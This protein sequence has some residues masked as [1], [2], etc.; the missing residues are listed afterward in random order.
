MAE[1][2]I[3]P[4]VKVIKYYAF[5]MCDA[6]SSVIIPQSVSLI[7]DF[8]FSNCI[9]LKKVVINSNETKFNK[10][11]FAIINEKSRSLVSN[12]YQELNC[13]FCQIY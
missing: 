1:I 12:D 9:S 5:Y 10:K 3:P 7:E 13:R 2:N 6:L 4:T 11:A 8:A